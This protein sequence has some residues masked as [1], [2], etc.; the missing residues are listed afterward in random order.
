MLLDNSDL[1]TDGLYAM[2]RLQRCTYGSNCKA[3]V[4]WSVMEQVPEIM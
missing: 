3:E 2:S 1:A 4:D